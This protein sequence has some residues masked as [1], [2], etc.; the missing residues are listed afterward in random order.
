[1]KQYVGHSLLFLM[2][3]SGAMFI[4]LHSAFLSSTSSSVKIPGD[5]R[6]NENESKREVE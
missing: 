2:K 1:M 4:A 3:K 5:R 6:Q